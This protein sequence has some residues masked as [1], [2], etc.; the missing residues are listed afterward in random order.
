[1][2]KTCAFYRWALILGI[3]LLVGCS[4]SRPM[5]HRNKDFSP[6]LPTTMLEEPVPDGSIYTKGVRDGLFGDSKAY[7]VGDL[8]TI[9]LQEDMSS[10][11]NVSNNLNRKTTN[12]LL[13]GLQRAALAGASAFS[14]PW[15]IASDF[16]DPDE[17]ET[18]QQLKNESSGSSGHANTLFGQISASVVRVLSNKNLVVRGEKLITLNQGDEYIQISGIIRPEDVLPDNTVLSFRVANAQITY[19]GSGE[20]HDATRAGWGTSLL[21]KIWPF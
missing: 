8:I 11:K 13:T 6:V 20:V 15:M 2:V 18:E 12:S 1:M 3:T 4:T 19:S 17:A 14:W 21:Y 16:G 10:I 5:P 9:V 7:R